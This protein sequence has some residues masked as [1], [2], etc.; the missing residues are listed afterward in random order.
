MKQKKY[1]NGLMRYEMTD[2]DE[3]LSSLRPGYSAYRKIFEEASG[4]HA[5]PYPMYIVIEAN[6]YCNMRCKMCIKSM[7][8]SANG[9]DNIDMEVL[10]KLLRDAHDIGV[11]SFF[12]GGATECL[13]NPKILTIM[14]HIREIGKGID[15]V[16]ITNGY[17]LTDEVIDTL[18]E[19]GWEKVFISLD[20]ATPETY[21]KIRGRDLQHV[22]KNIERLLEKRGGSGKLPIVRVS[23]CVQ[24]ENAS[25]KELFFE[26][27]KDK[28]D[29]IDFQ[30][31]SHYEDMSVLHDLPPTKKRCK[32]PFTNPLMD[33]YGNIYP[34]CV[35][36]GKKMPLGNIK[37]QSLKELW[38]G[39][40]I[41]KL[42]KQIMSGELCDIC[43]TCLFRTESD[44]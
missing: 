40:M 23:F 25:E 24:E 7:D 42:R 36:W 1:L 44:Y 27:W 22:E 34:C 16:L 28:V 2:I 26:K 37:D 41:S 10:D 11:P 29:I 12:L 8:E 31:L 4:M 18:L 19:L 32:N 13:I 17:E 43:K 33:C 6:N 15:D 14:R 9:Q 5:Q 38:N 30:D 3:T 21:R 39:E 20:A 35:E